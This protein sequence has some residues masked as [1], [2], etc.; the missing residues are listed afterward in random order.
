M[1]IFWEELTFGLPDTR[2]LI[3]VIIRLVAATLL[4]AVIGIDRERAGKAAGLRTHILVTLGTTVFVLACSGYG[5]SSD[6]LSRVIQGIVT[7][8]GFIGAGSILKLNEER[9]VQ[10]LTTS[11]GIWMTAAIG[12]AVGLGSLGIA[13]L[14]TILTFIILSLAV[15]I[16]N[17]FIKG[18]E[19]KAKNA[20]T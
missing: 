3:H 11:A 4:G 9:D 17:R 2:Q 18:Q 14:A 1:D 20:N 13:I 8:I 12:V 7:G 6:G 16:E 5:M 15:P 19:N 10:G